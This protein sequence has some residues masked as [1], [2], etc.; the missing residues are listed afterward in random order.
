MTL[1]EE[2]PE[3]RD[4]REHASESRQQHLR[5]G[6]CRVSTGQ[7][8]HAEVDEEGPHCVLVVL[9]PLRNLVQ[10][11]RQ[12]VDG[13][14][15]GQVTDDLLQHATEAQ[16]DAVLQVGDAGA[17]GVQRLLSGRPASLVGSPG[18]G[19]LLLQDGQGRRDVLLALGQPFDRLGVVLDPV[20]D[21]RLA[22]GDAKTL[23]LLTL[24]QQGGGDGLDASGLVRPGELGQR[25]A[26]LDHGLRDVC[27]VLAVVADRDQQV[28]HTGR[29]RLQVLDTDTTTD[30]DSL[31][32]LGMSSARLPKTVPNRR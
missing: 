18:V 20:V 22:D 29:Q 3:A 10:R 8:E 23:Q 11:R 6:Q 7:D 19:G 14:T 24:A 31:S 5:E 4:H 12:A 16:H 32:P 27:G 28:L 13:P 17:E 26:A 25:D 1:V 15:S 21:L 9:D 30:R 2:R